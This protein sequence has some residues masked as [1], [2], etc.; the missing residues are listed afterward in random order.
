MKRIATALAV[1]TFVAAAA[2][3]E[4]IVI[5]APAG[6]TAAPT[7]VA[8]VQP[9]VVA[10]ACSEVE[11]NEQP[12]NA[13]PISVPGSC[14]GFASMT[15]ASG[16][17]INYGGGLTDG[18]EDL[19]VLNVAGGQRLNIT[20]SWTDTSGDLD[21]FL[22]RPNGSSLDIVDG[23]T[24]NGSAPESITTGALTAGTYYIGISAFSGSSNYTLNV[25]LVTASSGCTQDNTTACLSNGRFRVRATYDTGSQTGSGGAVRLTSDTGY[26]WFFGNANVEMVVKILDACSFNNRF[27]VFA[28]GLTDV[29]VSLNITDT[30]SGVTKTYS[31]ARGTAFKPI[32]DTDAFATCGAAPACSYALSPGTQSFASGGGSGTVAMTAASG[33]SWS[34][35]SNASWIT[36]NSGASGSGNG[37]I[38][39]SVA[40]NGGASRSGTITANGQSATITQ[41]GPSCTYNLSPSGTSYPTSGGSGTIGVSA[42]SGCSWN[43]SSNAFWIT[44]TGGASGSGNGTVSYSVAAN[45]GSA[46]NSSITVAGQTVPISQAGASFDGNW[47]GTTSQGKSFTFTVTGNGIS[48]FT[49]NWSTT[50]GSC[51]A[52]G[53]TTTTFNPPQAISG[54]SFSL[55]VP[56]SPAIS[57][58]GTFASAN[59]AS[60]NFSVTNP[61]GCPSSGSG[62]WNATKP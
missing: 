48:T 2:A 38:G 45:G 27:W 59:S 10:A 23:S 7:G 35:T 61:F 18:I 19:F 26:F 47:S 44:I 49:L 54:S 25:A 52:T 43:A 20:L 34:A 22:L 24:A 21:L 55:S 37:T 32:Q 5:Q 46:R 4:Q 56:G 8:A 29:G 39:F 28:G 11:P 15:D 41:S 12:A 53:T 36:I 60:G 57:I 14:S 50:G 62:T 40:A 31:N 42:A 17:T 33:C 1:F 3:A 16:I 51:S 30:Q 13:S 6:R 58:S 9:A